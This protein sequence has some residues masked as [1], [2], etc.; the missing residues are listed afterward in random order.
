[1][2]AQVEEKYRDGQ[3]VGQ[4]PPIQSRNN[5]NLLLIGLVIFLLVKA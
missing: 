4:Y 2:R 3:L 5:T 1:M